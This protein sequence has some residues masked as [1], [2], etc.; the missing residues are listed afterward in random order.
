MNQ[1]FQHREA[2]DPI[3]TRTRDSNESHLVDARRFI[4][5]IWQECGQFVDVN[6]AER[7]S[8][9]LAPVFWELYLAYSLKSA[10]IELVPR[11]GR[12]PAREGPDLRA[13]QPEVWLEAV[14]PTCGEGPDALRPPT[15]GEAFKVPTD[16]FVL[17]LRSVIE[18]KAA[19]LKKHADRGLIKDGQASIIAISGI[20]LQHSFSE[21][22]VPRI[23][24][25]VLGLGDLVLEI[26]RKSNTISGRSV[27][28]RDQV[29]RQKG[30]QIVPIKT[31][32]FRHAAYAHISAVIYSY[33]NWVSHI[34]PGAD[35]TLVCTTRTRWLLCL[36]GGCRLAMS[37]GW[38]EP[39]S[40]NEFNTRDRPGR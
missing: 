1:F 20:R 29:E 30:E 25:S 35:F 5:H 2:R 28:Y 14:A 16:A 32:V 38:K 37:I 27:E 39:P 34:A 22:P 24:R 40:S 4:E 21:L 9:A 13:R 26:D 31:D 3:Y 23:V 19:Q 6:A 15:P 33:S 7:A 36:M 17:R 18:D 12:I 8:Q 10:G 11:T